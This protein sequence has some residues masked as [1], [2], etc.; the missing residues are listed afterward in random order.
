MRVLSLDEGRPS[1]SELRSHALFRIRYNL[2]YFRLIYTTTKN[3]YV[4][5]RYTEEV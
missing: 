2:N 3:I 4:Q 5:P 1:Q